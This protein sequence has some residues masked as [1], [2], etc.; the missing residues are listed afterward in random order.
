MAGNSFFTSQTIQK[1][2]LLRPFPQMASGNGLSVSN[3]PLGKNRAK[4]IEVTRSRR[5]ANGFS[6]NIVYTG[7]RAEELTT[8][9]EY[10]QV[11]GLWQTTDNAK[12]HR[13]TAQFLV[14]FPFGKSKP[15]L[16]NGGVLSAIFGGWQTGGTFEY[17]SGPLLQW[18]GA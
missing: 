2:R 5:F 7:M 9:N 17:Q 18:S 8:V 10:D 4:S 15:F 11:P 13:V 14:E 1:N 6:G 3:L 16:N 12:P